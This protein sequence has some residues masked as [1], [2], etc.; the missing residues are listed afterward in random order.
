MK[1]QAKSVDKAFFQVVAVPV[2]LRSALDVVHHWRLD[3]VVIRTRKMIIFVIRAYHQY[4]RGY[5]FLIGATPKNG[6]VRAIKKWPT[7]TTDLVLAGITEKRL[8]LRLVEKRFLAKN[9]FLSPS[10]DLGISLV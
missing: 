6:N 4:T 8:F 9:P 1:E 10:G 5:N 3:N 2:V 7:V